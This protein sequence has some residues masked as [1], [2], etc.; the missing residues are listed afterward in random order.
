MTV[1]ATWDIVTTAVTCG[2]FCRHVG[3]ALSVP[4]PFVV[5]VFVPSGEV[6]FGI[7]SFRGPFLAMP[8]DAAPIVAVGA[9]PPVQ[10]TADRIAKMDA[11]LQSLLTSADVPEEIMATIA[12]KRITSVP[13]FANLADSRSE[14]RTFLEKVLKVDPEED[15]NHYVLVTTS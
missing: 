15:E 1:L 4:P 14:F 11:Q 7:T 8:V 9:A 6:S 12:D 5:F 10:S 3:F 2:F 13:L